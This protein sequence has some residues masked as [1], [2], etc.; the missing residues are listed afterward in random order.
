MKQ[1]PAD[2]IDL[3]LIGGGHAQIAVLKSFGMNPVAGVRLTLVT[4]VMLAPYSGMLPGYVE[5]HHSLEDMH[6]D[7]L[8]LARFAGARLIKRA[9]KDIDFDKQNIVLEGDLN[10]FYDVLSIN[11]GAVPAAEAIIG[12]DAHAITVKPIS[13]FLEKMPVP[14]ELHGDIAVIGGGAAGCELAISL[15]RHYSRA[16]TPARCHLFSRSARLL[17]TAPKAASA[18]MQNALTQN[19]I[20]LHQNIAVRQ[21]GY[22]KQRYYRRWQQNPGSTYFCCNSRASGGVDFKPACQPL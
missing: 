21:R 12:T 16:G 14:A 20:T 13:R 5:G 8:K 4:D 10:L 17:P 9:V 2:M 19:Q 7:L 22:K 15:Q 6:I 11:C 1:T 18:H 3:V